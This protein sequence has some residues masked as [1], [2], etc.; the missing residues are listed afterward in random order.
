MPAN[1]QTKVIVV[2]DV[3]PVSVTR[4]PSTPVSVVEQNRVIAEQTIETPPCV[5]VSNCESGTPSDFPFVPPIPFSY[6]DAPGI[7]WTA[8]V[9]G[10]FTIAR[11]DI[12]TP[13]N[14]AGATISVGVIGNITALLSANEPAVAAAYEDAADYPVLAG[15]GIW[16]EIHPGAGASQGSG[17]L[18]VTFVPES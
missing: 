10:V 18:Y 16:L 1:D 4:A 5:I 11:L 6:G 2:R 17:T 9:D 14:G 7:V 13:F 12:E 15:T 3:R 8:P